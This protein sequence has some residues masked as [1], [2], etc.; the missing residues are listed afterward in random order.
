M[1]ILRALLHH[2]VHADALRE[3]SDRRR[4][5]H[6]LIHH[7]EAEYIEMAVEN[8]AFTEDLPGF[9]MF[10]PIASIKE[11]ARIVDLSDLDGD[12]EDEDDLSDALDTQS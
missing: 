7:E 10:D 5:V 8:L 2:D 6:T 9:G 3:H 1:C 11:G 4:K 12:E